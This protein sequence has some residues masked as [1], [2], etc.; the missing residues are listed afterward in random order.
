MNR[1]DTQGI[2]EPA[3]ATAE[4]RRARWVAVV[5]GGV[6]LVLIIG[7]VSMVFFIQSEARLNAVG[8]IAPAPGAERGGLVFKG[9]ANVW[10]VRGRMTQGAE[11]QVHFSFDLI[12]PN[13][14]PAP[15]SL[16]LGLSLDRPGLDMPPIPLGHNHNGM[17]SYSASTTLPQTGRWR[18]RIEFIEITG[19]F[20]FD[21]EP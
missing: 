9:T 7:F 4:V 16:Y 10:E 14:Q 18:L 15:R 12:G 11:R 17:G 19:L 6:F 13:G 1:P 2:R 20:E 3:G 21:V 5:F 8:P